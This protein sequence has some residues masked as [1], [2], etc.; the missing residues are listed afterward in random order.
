MK[1]EKTVF[2][3]TL[4]I[5]KR[6]YYSWYYEIKVGVQPTCGVDGQCV[7]DLY[8]SYID[9]G[10]LPHYRVTRILKLKREREDTPCVR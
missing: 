3:P 7:R 8:K 2:C 9:L 4:V 1:V 5:C 10:D 6:V